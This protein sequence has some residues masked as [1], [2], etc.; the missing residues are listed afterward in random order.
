VGA[1]FHFVVTT[2]ADGTFTVSELPKG[3]YLIN[4]AKTGFVTTFYGQRPAVETGTPVAIY[5]GAEPRTVELRL[6]SGGRITGRVVDLSGEPLADATVEILQYRWTDERLRLIPVRTTRT[7]DRGQYRTWDLDGGAYYVR[8][9]AL[10]NTFAISPAT[11]IGAS[12]KLRD[13]GRSQQPSVQYAPT[14]YP[15]A[16]SANDAIAIPLQTGQEL[17]A[18]VWLQKLGLTS[19]VGRVQAPDGS[20][21]ANCQLAVIPVVAA[22]RAQLGVLYGGRTAADGS[23]VIPNVPPGSYVLHAISELAGGLFGHEPISVGTDARAEVHI[24]LAAAATIRGRMR[25][26][27]AARYDFNRTTVRIV[28]VEGVSSAPAVTARVNQRG[29]FVLHGVRPSANVL[30]VDDG[31]GFLATSVLIDGREALD[32]LIQ[33]QPGQ[34]LT[35]VVTL[36][37]RL[38][39]IEG[40]LVGGG[41]QPRTDR[42]ILLF[43]IDREN[44]L[45]GTSRIRVQQPD[46]EGRFEITGFPPGRY[47]MTAIDPSEY[48]VWWS[49]EF[50]QAQVTQAQRLELRAGQVIAQDVMIR[51]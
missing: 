12:Q 16:L 9:R 47:F 36:T 7:D 3:R 32:S 30:R 33:A 41:G 24:R 1:R 51:D 45:P 25:L 49:P 38:S 31:S 29:E 35:A 20:P 28:D 50:L 5:D 6:S 22:D 21:A 8:V 4:A 17:S 39:R 18:D 44:W 14:Y 2:A 37:D 40:R 27:S 42:A 26:D 13:Q 34:T 10:N 19:L 15:G 43:P 23:F 48:G 46:S 11:S